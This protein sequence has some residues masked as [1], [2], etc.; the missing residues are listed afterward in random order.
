MP[1]QFD[2]ISAWLLRRTSNQTHR[3]SANLGSWGSPLIRRS[4]S[5]TAGQ[6]YTSLSQ[7]E[8]LVIENASDYE[9]LFLVH[10]QDHIFLSTH[11]LAHQ[12]NLQLRYL[13]TLLVLSC[14]NYYGP[15][16]YRFLSDS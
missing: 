13:V 10:F 4:W 16:L 11:K 7:E 6:V 2:V 15:T 12:I 1:L 3:D 14:L 8:L 9:R 5:S